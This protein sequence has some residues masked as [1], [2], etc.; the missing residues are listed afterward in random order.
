[1]TVSTAVAQREQRI[2]SILG[3]DMEDEELLFEEMEFK[4]AVELELELE[5]S[6][7]GEDMMGGCTGI[8]CV[9]VCL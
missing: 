3:I 4:V 5:E 2:V 6:D 8:E 1:M 9:L 7:D